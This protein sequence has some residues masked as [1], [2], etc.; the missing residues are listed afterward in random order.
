MPLTGLGAQLRSKWP[1][2]PVLHQINEGGLS[3]G[4][5]Q[6][7]LRHQPVLFAQSLPWRSQVS[8]GSL[9]PQAGVW[10]SPEI[11]DA[12][13]NY[14][15]ENPNPHEGAVLPPPA[16]GSP[17]RDTGWVTSHIPES[18]LDPPD[19]WDL[20]PLRLSGPC[21]P[22]QPRAPLPPALGGRRRSGCET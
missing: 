17:Q 12:G 1:L 11:N 8:P 3:S 9:S 10:L 14:P 22:A 5:G 18:P 7:R 19:R 21:R 16:P 20:C 4:E 6:P 13:T 15:V 2:S